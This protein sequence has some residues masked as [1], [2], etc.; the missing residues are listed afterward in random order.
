MTLANIYFEAMLPIW[1][2]IIYTECKEIEN[3]PKYKILKIFENNKLK[4]F[5]CYHDEG[6]I[7]FLDYNFYIG[8][9]KN[10]ALKFFKHWNTKEKTMKAICQVNNHKIRNFLINIGF[11]LEKT[12]KVNCYYIKEVIKCQQ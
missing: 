2:D 1:F 9:N 6:D 8:K 12:E 11:K 3:D 4:G 5:S 10:I 7:R